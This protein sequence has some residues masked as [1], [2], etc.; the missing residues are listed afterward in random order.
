MNLSLFLYTRLNVK[1]T[2]RMKRIK[3]PLP[4]TDEKKKVWG[5]V[6]GGGGDLIAFLL[7]ARGRGG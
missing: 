1:F 3:V 2:D 6:A 7:P 5:G 4:P